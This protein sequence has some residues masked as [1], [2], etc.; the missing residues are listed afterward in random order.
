MRT[1]RLSL[2]ALV[3]NLVLA[4]PVLSQSGKAFLKEAD[5]L[6][7]EQ[8]FEQAL[9]KYDFA[10]RTDPKLIKAYQGR[11]ET[12]AALGRP[13]QRAQ[14][15]GQAAQLDPGESRYAVDA[16][17]A[18]LD[19]DSLSRAR[20]L[21]EQALLVSPK[22]QSAM[23]VRAKAC[24]R[25]GD[26][27]CAAQASD[28]A[29][30][31][32]GTTDSFFMHGLVRTATRD[33][34]TAE[35]DL[36]KVLEWNYLYEPAYV[37]LSEVQL[38][39]YE[40]YS[41]P[42]MKLRTLEKAIEKCTRALELNPRSTDAL[43]TRSKAFALQKE[44]AK[45]IDDISRCIALERT[46]RAVYL[47][48]ARYYQGFGQFQNAVND[49]NQIILADPQDAEALLLRAE[50]RESNLNLEGALKDI[51]AA[52][53]AKEAKGTLTAEERTAF[54]DTR[55]RIAKQ[56]F[57][58]NREAD[59][60]AITVI[61]PFRAGDVAR[62]SASLEFVKVSGHVRDKSLLKSITANGKPADFTKDEK[63]PEFVVSIPL[64]RDAVE[65]VVQATDVYDNFSS[66][67]LSVERTEGVPPTLAL[68]SPK[69]SAAREVVLPHGRDD[70]FIEGT[71]TD[72]SPI[73]LIAV[74]GVNASYAPDRLNPDF[75]IKVDLKDA[76]SFIVRAEDQFGNATE[77]SWTVRREAAP[78]AAKPLSVESNPTSS[79]K[80]GTWMIQIENSNYRNLPAVQTSASDQARMQK[81]FASYSIQRTITKKNMSKEQLERF[82]N[83]ELR[84]LVRTNK[85][86]TIL[87]WYSGHGR[88][89]GG[90]AYWIPIDGKKDDIYS[91]YNYGALKAQMQ[92]YSESVTNTIVVSDAAAGDASFYDLT[93]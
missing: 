74:N 36:D 16:A 34:K 15:L 17:S 85:V 59:P 22:D 65:I 12:Y 37:A 4:V 84:D 70:L 39:L 20:H 3:T 33:Y 69:P 51:D 58:M 76:D 23:L 89:V 10:I 48:R 47:Q 43:F 8:Q 88:T 60:P 93:R 46:D 40:L 44:Y 38:A 13:L 72:A 52:Q 29:L 41:G 1:L 35:F 45:A 83:V 21:A 61:E 50:C 2:A 30:A 18:F 25:S 68:T 62:V 19:V 9:E 11:A 64:A 67:V 55:A 78:I 6:R 42:T 77:Q 79:A 57:E 24:L 71:V 56:V 66:E 31:L 82:F 87:V 73:R 14:D 90:K 28:A 32:K 80:G 63:D 53:K 91:F 92:N 7:A 5:K 27:D 54:D 26:L 75:S 81:A 86:G 49:L